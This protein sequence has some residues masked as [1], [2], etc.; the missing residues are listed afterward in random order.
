MKKILSFV[1][2]LSILL[3]SS[4]VC[5]ADTQNVIAE[6]TDS[7]KNDNKVELY[8]DAQDDYSAYLENN[9]DLNKDVQ[10]INADIKSVVT[11]DDAIIETVVEFE[12]KSDV[13][14]WNNGEGSI[15]FSFNVLEEGLYNI[16]L[17]YY[18]LEA[19]T[20]SMDFS[21]LIDG[22][23]PFD[24]VDNISVPRIFVDAG[25][26][27]K[28]GIGNEFAPEQKEVFAWQ[29]KRITDA[30]GLNAKPYLFAFTKGE[31]TLTIYDCSC[32]VAIA[33]IM[34][35]AEE[36][37]S[38]YQDVLKTYK[39][40]GYTNYKGNQIDIQ[41]EKAYLKS[42]NNLI[43]QSDATSANVTPYD[44]LRSK[45]NYIGGNNWSGSGDTI[46]WEVVVPEDGLYS[47]TFAYQQSYIV[48]GS[49]YRVLRVDGEIPFAEA[50]EINFDYCNKWDIKEFA[51]KSGTPYLIYLKE[52]R[53]VLSLEVNLGCLSEFATE[54]KN[55]IYELGAIY[56]E[57]VMITGETPDSNRDYSLFTQIP[58]LEERL[59]KCYNALNS[60][61]AEADSLS[62]KGSSGN[63]AT[64][65]NMSA[66]IKRMLDY[67]YQAQIYKSSFY[68]N[69]SSISA[70]LYEII[71]M[72]LDIDAI[73]ITS[74][75]KK[76][77]HL[78]ADFWERLTFGLKRFLLSW[79]ADYNSISG[80]V[81][82]DSISLWVNW[83]RDQVQVLNYLA[84]SDFTTSTGIG[85]DI[86][87]T[88]A[89]LIQGILSGNGPDCYL[90]MS[91]TEP[92]NLAMRGGL[93]DL[94][95]FKDFDEVSSR[96]MPTATTPYKYKDGV[97]ALPDTQTFSVM[98][99]RQDILDELGVEVPET[100]DDFIAASAII[101]RNNMQVGLPYTQI[102]DMN[103]VNLGLG[104]LNIYPTLLMQRGVNLYDDKFSSVDM[105]SEE[106][107]NT[108]T[109]WTD[110]YNKYSFPKT[111]DFYNRFRT[112]TMPLAIQ[113]CTQYNTISAAAS[114][115][116]GLWGITLIPGTMDENGN[117]NHSQ[118]GAGTGCAILKSS[119]NIDGAWEFLK[120]WTR[121]DIQLKYSQNV[122]S[123]LGITGRNMT[124][125]VEALSGLSWNN[126]D[127]EILK[128]QWAL[129]DEMPE[130]PGGYYVPR[131]V[132][133]AFWNVVGNGKGIEET[134]LKW[135][136][137]AD[138][139]IAEKQSQYD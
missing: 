80:D 69:Y 123:I 54:L 118:A 34:L 88:N 110:F 14:K 2:A 133:Q 44:S 25:E 107:V 91:R 40:L 31:H 65:K 102:T 52:G 122:E 47:I 79:S 9:K 138:N 66:V 39:E 75:E 45:V 101:M 94:S 58:D 97:Y 90:H 113:S 136:K 99:Y 109:M 89:T 30:E 13:L 71:N 73:Y 132:D 11:T 43:S 108:F 42:S 63:T 50:A 62:E 55:Q 82:E 137:V 116:R 37:I 139:E 67:K 26:V 46:S 121:D 119:D 5:F 24:G 20:K 27:R 68:D 61:I 21:I 15:T 77:K 29:N 92:V 130:V 28:D 135:D 78:G 74:P 115:I 22:N 95:Q 127:F 96:F 70:W 53:R 125:N 57:I 93:Y 86:K 4:F 112:G 134:L 85:V 124:S 84:Q 49:S 41:G 10:E 76:A 100:W 1:I 128:E 51:D 111:Y 72:P 106:A 56:R 83:G 12:G 32:P 60:L 104:A 126:D 18:M 36:K 33:A 64:L 17:D 38:S 129:V 105:T 48:N 35:C 6:N 98:F 120:W 59:K 131:V 23:Q 87:M 3:V 81:G 103:Q 114:E 8:S 16:A 19:G 117:V 7:N